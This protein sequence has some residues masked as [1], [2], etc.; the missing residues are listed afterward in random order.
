M[1][2][3]RVVEPVPVYCIESRYSRTNPARAFD[4]PIG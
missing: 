2:R 1:N 3:N 4:R